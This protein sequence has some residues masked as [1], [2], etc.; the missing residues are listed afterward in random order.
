MSMHYVYISY[1]IVCVGGSKEVVSDYSFIALKIRQDLR[2]DVLENKLFELNRTRPINKYFM[3]RA[4]TT[5][6]LY[7]PIQRKE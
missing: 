7:T 2:V 3:K 4:T 1:S 6:Q 5:F